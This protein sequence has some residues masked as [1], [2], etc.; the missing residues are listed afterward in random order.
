[1]VIRE[2]AILINIAHANDQDIQYI[3]FHR[4]FAGKVFHIKKRCSHME[5]TP[6]TGGRLHKQLTSHYI[7]TGEY[8]RPGKH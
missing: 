2:Y 1:M 4:L 8:H 3:V 6:R 5:W 7:L